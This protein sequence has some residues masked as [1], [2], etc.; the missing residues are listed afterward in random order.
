MRIIQILF[1]KLVIWKWLCNRWIRKK[2]NNHQEVDYQLYIN[3]KFQKNIITREKR[4]WR[5]L[6]KH[7]LILNICWCLTS[8]DLKH[9]LI[10]SIPITCDEVTGQ[11]AGEWRYEEKIKERER[12]SEGGGDKGKCKRWRGKTKQWMRKEWTKD[13]RNNNA[14]MKMMKK[15]YIYIP[16]GCA[17][18]HIIVIFLSTVWTCDS[19]S[20]VES[21]PVSAGAEIEVIQF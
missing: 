17:T 4:R 14:G 20:I 8:V 16:L 5:E 7:L 19:L 6:W 9:L 13:G 12:E 1:S 18:P 11:V 3:S 10:L 15:K 2:K 21:L